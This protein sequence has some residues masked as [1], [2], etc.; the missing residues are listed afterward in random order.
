[1]GQVVTTAVLSM[2]IAAL[3]PT[4]VRALGVSTIEVE[5]RRLFSWSM[6][7]SG[8]TEGVDL[9]FPLTMVFLLSVTGQASSH[10]AQNG[11]IVDL[12][13]TTVLVTRVSITGRVIRSK[14]TGLKESGGLI[15]GAALIFP[16]LMEAASQASA[17]QTVR[18][19]SAA[20]S[21]VTVG[22]TKNTVDALN[23]STM[24]AE[25]GK[26]KITK[27]YCHYIFQNIYAEESS[28]WV[29]KHRDVEKQLTIAI[30]KESQCRC[31]EE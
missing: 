27:I 20:Q 8:W 5:K 14:L 28:K 2:G 23:A 25:E 13:L 24:P 11:V 15:V 4:T 7:G 3:A 22:A 26:V 17:T 10:A 1:M 12:D 18:L 21:G 9:S 19:S 30:F 16:C 6:G 31:H 29:K